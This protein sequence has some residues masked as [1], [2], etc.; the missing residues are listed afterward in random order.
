[1]RAKTPLIDTSLTLLTVGEDHVNATPI[2]R[3]PALVPFL[4]RPELAAVSGEAYRGRTWCMRGCDL[5]P[6]VGPLGQFSESHSSGT[7]FSCAI[8]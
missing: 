8:L 4:Y 5:I 1:M 7:I 2:L 3:C 6:H